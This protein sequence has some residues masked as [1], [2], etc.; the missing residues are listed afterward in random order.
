MSERE[1]IMAK[2][3]KIC[4]AIL[5]LILISVSMNGY[6]SADTVNPEKAK[7]NYL[8]I[9]TSGAYYNSLPEMFEYLIEKQNGVKVTV[10][11]VLFSSRSLKQHLAAIKA[12]LRTKGD[13][14]RLTKKEK[15]YFMKVKQNVVPETSK[16][17]DERIYE[18]YKNAFLTRNGKPRLYDGI[19][20]QEHATTLRGYVDK[21]TSQN[22]YTDIYV[23]LLK[24]MQPK[25]GTKIIVF[26]G[27]SQFLGTKNKT[28]KEQVKLD[29]EA[30]KATG[31]IKQETSYDAVTAYAGM[32]WVNYMYYY[33]ENSAA[34]FEKTLKNYPH[35]N[36]LYNTDS[37]HPTQIGSM[38]YANVLYIAM[39]GKT[40]NKPGIVYKGDVK[41]GAVNLFNGRLGP[42]LN[43]KNPLSSK[44]T[45]K[46][47][48]TIA[49]MTQTKGIR[50][51]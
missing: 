45:V 18:G 46:H 33:G 10:N 40:P 43:N 14:S 21:G 12:V 27:A 42:L 49:V 6:V 8:F 35:L 47:C 38:I 48:R 11:Y 50:L 31:R 28:R 16:T 26:S 23:D 7:Q 13:S 20:F 30:D 41:D 1:N 44:K 32:S 19:I 51:K 22:Y 36:D 25:E 17:F 24:A 29:K 3:K 37:K 15:P 5:A 39:F 4:I 34:S 9:G 2:I